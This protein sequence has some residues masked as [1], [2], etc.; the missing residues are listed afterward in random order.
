MIKKIKLAEDVIL[1]IVKSS[2]AV[3]M[4][5]DQTDSYDDAIDEVMDVLDQYFQL[6][7]L[8]EE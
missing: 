2:P 6:E 5:L 4:L 3:G 1:A 7:D 8:S